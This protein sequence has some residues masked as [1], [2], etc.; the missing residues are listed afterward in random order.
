MT[1]YFYGV[2][3]MGYNYYTRRKTTN[4]VIITVLL[5][6]TE[7]SDKKILEY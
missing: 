7:N 2:Y 5:L 6:A 1:T 3:F 4:Y